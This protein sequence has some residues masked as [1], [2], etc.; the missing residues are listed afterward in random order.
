MKN[1]KEKIKV[2]HIISGL[3]VGGT[4][5]HLLKILP[6]MKK[7]EHII[8]SLRNQRETGDMLERQGFR[9]Y[10]LS[11]GFEKSEK[12]RKG[13]FKGI[14][15]FKSIIKE[16]R[17]DILCTY[18]I[19]ADLFGRFFGRIFGMKKIICNV[20]VVF[21]EGYV[22]EVGRIPLM[23]ERLS[24]WMNAKYI[25]NSETAKQ[26]LVKE[27]GLNPR[28]ISVIVNG[29]DLQKIDSIK[30]NR[31]DRIKKRKSLGLN[32]EDF[33]ISC[34]GRLHEQ[35][36]QEYLI[37]AI[38]LLK[39]NMKNSMKDNNL[40][41]LLIGD[42]DKKVEYIK[43]IKELGLTGKI[44]LLGSRDDT[45]HIL[46]SSDLFVLPTNY[47]GMSNAI[48]EAMACSLPIIV[49]EIP[50]NK[51]LIT[52]GKQGLLVQPRNPEQ[53][54]EKIDFLVHDKKKRGVLARNAYTKVESY[55]I[56]RCAMLFEEEY[57]KMANI[58]KSK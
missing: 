51:E 55:T 3:G 54:A 29:I 10:Y 17:P 39:N 31:A 49:T 38:S 12:S 19:Q 34:V 5:K 41:C 25:T 7:T 15:T 21:N 6:L 23:L 8:C 27:Q 20:R 48:L 22:K 11:E 33:V 13:L 18:L 42:G 36:G 24:S 46:K 14:K 56:R 28:N 26:S 16:E 53:L 30:M 52:D 58:R 44:R 35:K 4:E 45:I 40:K 43:Q 9:V 57:I 47:E 37:S 2:L 50:E 1:I 32:S